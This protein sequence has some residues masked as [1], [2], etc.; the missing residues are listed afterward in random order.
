MNVTR[1]FLCVMPVL[2]AATL[3]H[4]SSVEGAGEELTGGPQVRIALNHSANPPVVSPMSLE[5]LS[6]AE[7][8]EAN[9]TAGFSTEPIE[10]A[11]PMSLPAQPET[12]AGRASAADCLTAAIYYEAATE[13]VKGR[14]AVAQVVLN[15]VRHPAFPNS[16]CEVIMQGSGRTTGCQFTFTCDG[17]LYR[18]PSEHGWESARQIALAALSGMVEPSVGLATHYHADYVRPYW[19]ASLDKIAAVGTHVFYRWQGN[20]GKAQAFNQ[21]AAFHRD[22]DIHRAARWGLAASYLFDSGD[23]GSD[24]AFEALENPATQAPNELSGLKNPELP[25]ARPEANMSLRADREQGTLMADET[26]GTLILD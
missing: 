2:A 7:A 1:L 6:E 24:A 19:A 15:R 11:R 23:E 16:V 8:R 10:V 17:S 26:S 12:F 4:S 3:T 13:A 20:W 25:K 14:R 21:S 9:L 18:R 22:Y 5:P